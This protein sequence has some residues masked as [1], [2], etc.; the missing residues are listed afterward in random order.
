MTDAVAAVRHW[1]LPEGPTSASSTV[2][3]VTELSGPG[4]DTVA[5]IHPMVG[6]ASRRYVVVVDGQVSGTGPRAFVQ[7]L[8]R[9]GVLPESAGDAARAAAIDPSALDPG[10]MAALY[11]RVAASADL[12]VIDHPGHWAWSSVADEGWQFDPPEASVRDG[13]LVLR[14]WAYDEWLDLDRHEVTV[15]P[16]GEVTARPAH[17]SRRAE[18]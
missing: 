11:G 13:T 15:D 8:R 9:N 7:V 5:V 16:A 14:F 2:V 10:L 12:A 18:G 1:L 3:P 6:H 4:F 17:R